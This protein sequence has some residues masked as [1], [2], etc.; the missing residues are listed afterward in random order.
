[1]LKYFQDFKILKYGQLFRKK[2]TS[3]YRHHLFDFYPI[4]I[5]GA[6]TNCHFDQDPEGWSPLKNVNREI[7]ILKKKT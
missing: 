1:M 3:Q 5:P 2:K 4:H 6:H 7:Y